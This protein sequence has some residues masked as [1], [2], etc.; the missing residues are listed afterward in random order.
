M[1]AFLRDPG[2]NCSVFKAKKRASSTTIIFHQTERTHTAGFVTLAFLQSIFLFSIKIIS[3]T[4][5]NA[6]TTC[7][8]IKF[9]VCNPL[10]SAGQ[11]AV[12]YCSPTQWWANKD[13]F[14]WFE[15]QLC[16]QFQYQ[17]CQHNCC[18]CQSPHAFGSLRGLCTGQLARLY[19]Q[20]Q[21]TNLLQR[22]PVQP[23]TKEKK[24]KS[25]TCFSI[26]QLNYVSSMSSSNWKMLKGVEHAGFI[27][28]FWDWLELLTL[29]SVLSSHFQVWVLCNQTEAV[30]FKGLVIMLW[31]FLFP[32]ACWF[33]TRRHFE[34]F[35]RD[36]SLISKVCFPCPLESLS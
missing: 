30:S 19:R 21:E 26:G 31:S 18:C 24:K 4:L 14:M 3:L 23:F 28:S 36:R 33:Q 12:C 27:S 35:F 6:I 29:Y 20:P 7:W 25:R 15:L 10:N 8:R 5:N 22:W 13:G 34:N 16:F 17:T 1:W 9:Q 11:N 2:V 32:L